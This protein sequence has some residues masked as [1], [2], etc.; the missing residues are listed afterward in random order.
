MGPA[1]WASDDA[2]ALVNAALA[3]STGTRPS[4]G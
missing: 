4:G 2:K 3:A 1:E